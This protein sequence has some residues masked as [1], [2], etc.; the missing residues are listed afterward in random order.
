MMTESL[1]VLVLPQ[2]LPCTLG[3]DIL[4]SLR[5]GTIICAPLSDARDAMNREVA[6]SLE[7]LTAQQ[8]ATLPRSDPTATQLNLDGMR[9]ES[10]ATTT[11]VA[12]QEGLLN[13]ISN[14]LGCV[15]TNAHG[16]N[17]R[18]EDVLTGFGQPRQT[19]LNQ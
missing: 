6:K 17:T 18:I 8:L 10:T 5:Y 3:A 14:A 11:A 7:A 16:Q 1:Q 15:L 12:R 19:V 13:Q 9:A 4:L 2:S